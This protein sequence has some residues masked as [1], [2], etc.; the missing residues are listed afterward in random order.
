MG[1]IVKLL[2]FPLKFLRWALSWLVVAALLMLLLATPAEALSETQ[3]G[4]ISQNCSS[5]KQSLS[6]TQHNDSRTRSYLGTTYETVLNRLIVPLNVRLV[7]NNLQN[8]QLTRIQTDFTS[9]QQQ[10]RTSY[11]EY[12]NELDHT[13]AIDCRTQPDEFYTQ[14]VKTRSKRQT[15]RESTIRLSELTG[16]QYSAVTLLRSSL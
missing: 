9:A 4:A 5:I 10:F 12:M 7:K 2:L 1:F 13:I 14:L 11:I 15:L 6:I 16:E 3:R 8:Y